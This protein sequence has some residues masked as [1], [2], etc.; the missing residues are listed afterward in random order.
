M[1][2]RSIRN[3]YYVGL[4]A[5]YNNEYDKAAMYFHKVLAESEPIAESERDLRDFLLRESSRGLE[6]AKSKITSSCLSS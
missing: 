3:N 1:E 4:A 6:S 5:Y 2:P